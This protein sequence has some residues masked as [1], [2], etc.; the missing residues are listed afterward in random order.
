MPRVYGRKQGSNGTVRYYADLRDIGLGQHALTPPGSKRATSD[1]VEAEILK[2]RLIEELTGRVQK[3]SPGSLKAAGERLL[4]DNPKGNEEKWAVEMQR[5][6]DRAQGFFGADRP[7]DS[8]R[9][10]HIREWQHKLEKEGY[11]A[12]TVLHHLH[13]LSAVYGY[14]RELELVPSGYN[15]V[16]D[17]YG[18]PS[19]QNGRTKSKKADFL[20]IDEAARFLDAARRVQRV[21]RNGLI[22]FPEA[23]V[24][25][26]LLTGGRKAE[27]LGF[28]VKDVDFNAETVSIR[29]NAWRP[30]KRGWSE[31]TIPLWPQ[32]QEILGEY[33]ETTPP[34]GQLLFPSPRSLYRNNE[35]MI[36]DLRK[37]LKDVAREAGIS[38]VPTAKVFRHTYATARLQTTD[39][40]KQISLWT[41]AKE[42]GHKTVARV[43]DTYGHPSH[44]RPRGEVVEYRI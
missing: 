19:A 11:A 9:A 17:M 12:G 32:L 8:I 4:A 2:G 40:G 21:P 24:G 1:P 7:L 14:A 44:Y 37:M 30:L 39:G 33:L 43:E 16:S 5:Y 29:P 35:D 28:L 18:K 20:E 41:V 27:V 13:A 6:L 42:L 25:T 38:P 31:R 15:P 34:K 22:P 10:K 36:W 23:L 26:F 3:V